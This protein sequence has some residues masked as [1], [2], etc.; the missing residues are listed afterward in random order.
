MEIDM[1]DA[2]FSNEMAMVKRAGAQAERRQ[3]RRVSTRGR[4]RT[5]KFE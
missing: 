1:A 4:L 2:E 5:R 3:G